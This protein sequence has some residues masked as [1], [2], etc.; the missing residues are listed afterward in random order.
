MVSSSGCICQNTQIWQSLRAASIR[1]SVITWAPQFFRRC[2]LIPCFR[3]FTIHMS[4]R[5]RC[6]QYEGNN[7]SNN[8]RWFCAPCLHTLEKLRAMNTE[9]AETG[10]GSWPDQLVLV[11]VHVILLI[12]GTT[13]LFYL[14]FSWSWVCALFSFVL[15]CN[16]IWL[17]LCPILLFLACIYSV[18]WAIYTQIFFLSAWRFTYWFYGDTDKDLKTE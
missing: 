15:V 1:S 4:V 10:T 17:L 3:L 5:W 14:N 6:I 13:E 9:E 11:T 12:Q 7:K 8:L 2:R 18:T 16:I